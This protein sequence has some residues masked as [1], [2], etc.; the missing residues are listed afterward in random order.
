M[1]EDYLRTATFRPFKFRCVS[2][3]NSNDSHGENYRSAPE[4]SLL[5]RERGVFSGW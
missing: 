4:K 3:D 5:E 1:G 2:S